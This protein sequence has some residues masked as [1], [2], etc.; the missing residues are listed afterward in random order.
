M[1]A[2]REPDDAPQLSLILP[3]LASGGTVRVRVRGSS[4]LPS[5]WPGDVLTI[6]G[7]SCSEAVAGD[8]VL[9]LNEQR[10]LIHRIKE[11]RQDRNGQLQW[12]TQGDAVPQSDPAVLGSEPL[13]RVSMIERNHRFMVPRGLSVCLRLLAWMLCHWD[14]FRSICLRIHAMRLSIAARKE[15]AHV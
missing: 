14:R 13:G 8:I 10:L 9:V 12:I 4:M 3:V 2:S 11:K 1:L 5:L 15:F 6:E 7:L